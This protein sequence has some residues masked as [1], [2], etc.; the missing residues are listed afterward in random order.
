MRIAHIPAKMNNLVS[1]T[2]SPPNLSY[3]LTTGITRAFRRR[4]LCHYYTFLLTLSIIGA[5]MKINK[6]KTGINIEAETAVDHQIIEVIYDGLIS[7][8]KKT[9]DSVERFEQA[10]LSHA[11]VGQFCG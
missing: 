9:T 6:T 5:T 7:R 1:V 3:C 10:D 8:N 2:I 11:Q 4:C